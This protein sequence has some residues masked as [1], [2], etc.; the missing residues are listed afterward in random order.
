MG[1]FGAFELFVIFIAIILIFGGKKIP[2]LAKGLSK[3]LK[4]FR[5]A[6]YDLDDKSDTLKKKDSKIIIGKIENRKIDILVGT[7]LISKGFHFPKLNCIVV[8][9]AD[10]SS[11]GYDLRSAEKACSIPPDKYAITDLIPCERIHY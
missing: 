3:G 8:V 10:F 7:Q 4:E 6:I 9:D 5:K 2:E 1:S 11:H